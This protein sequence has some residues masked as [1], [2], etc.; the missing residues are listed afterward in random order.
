MA[1]DTAGMAPGQRRGL[2]DLYAMLLHKGTALGGHYRC[3]V[4]DMTAKA[5]PAMACGSLVA[6]EDDGKGE[7]FARENG[8]DGV[9]IDC[10]DDCLSEVSPEDL[11]SILNGG[12][13]RTGNWGC[14]YM[15]LYRSR[16][17]LMDS[18]QG[19]EIKVDLC[20]FDCL[21]LYLCARTCLPSCLLMRMCVCMS[22][23][24][25]VCACVSF[26][27]CVCACPALCDCLSV[28]PFQDDLLLAFTFRMYCRYSPTE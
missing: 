3:C 11:G 8:G 28:F 26:V 25:C 1:E 7:N 23:C 27:S 17:L 9:W 5:V 22:M 10:N 2:Y 20:A 18:Q 21:R 19:A 15:L 12:G 16:A 4:R 13:G 24:M 6:A 14:A